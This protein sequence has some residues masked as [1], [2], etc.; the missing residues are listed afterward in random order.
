[1]ETQV[2]SKI[3]N[4]DKDTYILFFDYYCG[5][6]VAALNFLKNNNLSYKG[7]EI[8][9]SEGGIASLLTYLNNNK[10]LLGYNPN[11]TTK[12]IIFLNGKFIGGFSDL[13]KYSQ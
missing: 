11:H 12:P 5:Y 2:I 4:A 10:D 3:V 8:S 7:Y 9:K 13:M 6:S 1:M